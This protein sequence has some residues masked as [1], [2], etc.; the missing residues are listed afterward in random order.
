MNEV[1]QIIKASLKNIYPGLP[2]DKLE[3]AAENLISY[4]DLI[5]RIYERIR[6]NPEAHQM[7]KIMLEEER[8][9]RS[10]P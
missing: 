4:T 7:F 5:N 9:R 1:E 8:K 6:N 3:E 2:E 10:R